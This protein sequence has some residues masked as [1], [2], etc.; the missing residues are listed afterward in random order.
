[1]VNLVIYHV[2]DNNTIS[3]LSTRVRYHRYPHMCD[4]IFIDL[5]P[6]GIPL[7]FIS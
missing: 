2:V 6:L 7:Y 5:L 3:L 1:M 4:N